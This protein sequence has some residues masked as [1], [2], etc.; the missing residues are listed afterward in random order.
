MSQ[1]SKSHPEDSRGGHSKASQKPEPGNSQPGT[2]STN[3]DETKGGVNKVRPKPAHVGHANPHP[4]QEQD[5]V[6][7]GVPVQKNR[8]AEAAKPSAAGRVAQ[9]LATGPHGK[10]KNADGSSFAE[11][12]KHPSTSGT[13]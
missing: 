10:Q 13:R 7:N 12:R 11:P 3:I 2:T 9:T 8:A 4:K 1:A 6:H 5:G